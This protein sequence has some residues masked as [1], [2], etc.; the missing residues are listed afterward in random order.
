[1]LFSIP[2]SPLTDGSVMSALF[3][4][5]QLGNRVNCLKG[6]DSILISKYAVHHELSITVQVHGANVVDDAFFT[7]FGQLKVQSSIFHS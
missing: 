5:V 3:E 4:V 7:V 1:M 2:L 6:I